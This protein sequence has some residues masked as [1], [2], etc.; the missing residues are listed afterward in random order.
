MKKILIA[1]LTCLLTFPELQ[2][3]ECSAYP[4]FLDALGFNAFSTAFST[5]ETNQPG[6]VAYE[7]ENRND[8]HS[9]RLKYFQ[10]QTWADAGFMGIITFDENGNIFVAPLPKVNTLYN[11][12]G[13]QNTIYMIDTHTGKMKPFFK[14]PVT[15][16]PDARNPYGI[17]GIFYD[18]AGKNLYVS[19]VSG[20]SKEQQKGKVYRLNTQNHEL[21]EI[22]NGLD[23]LG[24]GIF[25]IGNEK[26]LIYGEARNSTVW[27]VRLNDEGEMAEKQ[28][29]I[30]HLGGLGP[31][32]DD[33]GRKFRYRDGILEIQ[34]VPFMYNLAAPR[35]RQ[36]TTY[37]FR[38]EA[39]QGKWTLSSIQ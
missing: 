35:Q 4:K 6:I 10:D 7:L 13:D 20:S 2:S 1:A 36:E 34:G 22:M 31:R 25:H 39:Q 30:I 29:M 24:L 5:G 18:C 21:S 23:V 33:R 19:T 27:S 11:P 28:K 17:M 3:Q 14:L 32:G 16:I 8:L 12:P 15:D 26:F 38:Y 9:Q 37:S